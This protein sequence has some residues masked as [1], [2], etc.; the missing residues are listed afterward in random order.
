MMTPE[1]RAIL[2]KLAQSD[3]ADYPRAVIRGTASM[4]KR[5]RKDA[6]LSLRV[7]TEFIEAL[8]ESASLN[9]RSVSSEAL[10]LMEEGM[11]TNKR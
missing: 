9:G 11:R 7:P 3:P 4:P 5:P 6:M 2:E 8:Y 10:F 1:I